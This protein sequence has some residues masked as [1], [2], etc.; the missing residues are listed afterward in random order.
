MPKL[1]FIS[2]SA[3][4][5]F[6]CASPAQSKA[7]T[8]PTPAVAATEYAAPASD[9]LIVAGQLK[10]IATP[11]S[12][13]GYLHF[14]PLAEYTNLKILKGQYSKD[15]IYVVH[16]CP[17]LTRSEYAKG[18]GTL[19]SFQVGDYHLLHLTLQNVYDIGTIVP[20][21]KLKHLY[22]VCKEE[23]Q[24]CT[25]EE[26]VKRQNGTMYFASQVDLYSP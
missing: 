13:C 7:T 19:E 20:G 10:Y 15:T 9:E 3:L 26:F 23:S 24:G 14:G 16:G 6:A 25:A 11:L 2:L 22:E 21:E 5:L 18:S 8:A 17:E 1:F 4:L 12:H